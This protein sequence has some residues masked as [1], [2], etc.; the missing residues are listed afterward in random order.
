MCKDSLYFFLWKSIIS[1]EFSFKNIVFMTMKL[2][3]SVFCNKICEFSGVCKII[4]CRG[5]PLYSGNWPTDHKSAVP[6]L[7]IIDKLI[8]TNLVT[9]LS[10]QD[11][12]F[13]FFLKTIFFQSLSFPVHKIYNCYLWLLKSKNIW[14]NIVNWFRYDQSFYTFKHKIWDN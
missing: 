1:M 6:R 10:H 3:S 9:L 13:V 11:Y 4:S 5:Q 2:I 7:A 12:Q 8:I 14:K